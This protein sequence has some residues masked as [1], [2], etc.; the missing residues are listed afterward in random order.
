MGGRKRSEKRGVF[1]RILGCFE[2]LD[3]T[4]AHMGLS[5][6]NYRSVV[7]LEA[8]PPPIV[9]RYSLLLWV[10]APWARDPPTKLQ[11]FLTSHRPVCRRVGL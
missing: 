9:N 5:G 7:Y 3:L 11:Y 4:L 1:E 2:M 6:K 10:V 8:P